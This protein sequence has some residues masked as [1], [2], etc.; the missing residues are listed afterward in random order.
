MLDN[1]KD[2]LAR[3]KDTLEKLEGEISKIEA[4]DLVT[5]NQSLKTELIKCQSAMKNERDCNS[6]LSEENKNLKNALYEQLYN[7]KIQILNSSDKRLKAYYSSNIQGELNRLTAYEMS[8]KKRIDD[9]AGILR[10]NRIELSADMNERIDE[11]RRLLDAKAAEARTEL[12]K[13]AKAFSEAR[14]AEFERLRQEQVTDQEIKERVKQNNIEAFIGLN[15]INKIGILLLIIGVIAASQYTYFKLPDT[16]KCIFAFALGGALLAAGEILNRKK[17]NIFSLGITSGGIAILYAALAISFFRFEVLDKYPALGLCI[18]I[19]AGAFVLS[20]RYN[21]QTISVFAMVGGYLPVF[22]I[23]GNKAM[24]YGAMIYFVIL[25]V[26]ALIIS[27]KRKWSVTAYIGFWLNVA[28]SVYISASMLKGRWYDAPAS[29]EDI[30]TILYITF[31]FLIYTLIP[32][33]GTFREKLSFKNSDIVLLALNT[34]ISALILYSVFYA[35][36]LSD[37]TGLLAVAFA[38]VY[39]ALGRFVERRMPKEQKARALFYITGLTFAV[40]IIPFQFEH[41]WFSLGWLAEGIAI[42]SYGIYKEIKSFR[43]AGTVISLLC[44]LAFIGFDLTDI[45]ST[46]FVYKYLAVTA[47]SIIVLG[48]SAYK[49]KLSGRPVQ[50]FKYAAVINI[51][52][53]SLYIIGSKLDGL[54]TKLMLSGSFDSDYLITAAMVLASFTIAYI[55]PRL[56]ILFDSFMKALSVIIYV[57]GLIL[58]FALNFNSP[59]AGR[60]YEVPLPAGIL[61]TMELAA[62]ALL[63]VF[64]VRDM[65]LTLVTGKKL[66]IEWYPLIVSFY[67]VVILTQNLITQYNLEMNNAAISIIYLITA[68]SW[69]IFGFIRKYALIRRFGLGLCILAVAKLFLI[70]LSF[71]SQGHRV[72]SYFV[73]GVTLIAIS[74]VYQYFNKRIDMISGVVSDEKNN[75]G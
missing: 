1:L 28:G 70:D 26:F 61:G 6:K 3:Q 12:Q 63:S 16:L 11:L 31:A 27:G 36:N 66:G 52:F 2:I 67:S 5:E 58:L 65:V 15:I 13:N 32:V 9:M 47:G 40:L 8:V 34:V 46:L 37:C 55:I 74:F 41:V 42:L 4:N 49:K 59:V 50:V 60:L 64:V 68:F 25:N 75:N 29:G 62:I 72:V 56:K 24:L 17:P 45:S 10:Q 51:W 19:T 23:A 33:M 30:A 7:E 14:A 39:V 53:F 57:I 22:S 21:S 35:V 20:Q 48:I 44:L 73:F 38:A 71:L 69:I 43:R 18:L 54:L